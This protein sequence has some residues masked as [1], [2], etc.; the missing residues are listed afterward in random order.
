M[1]WLY[2]Y[3]AGTMTKCLLRRGVSLWEV[4]NVQCLYV[5][6]TMTKCLLRRDVCLWE[7]KNVVNV[8][9]VCGL[10]HD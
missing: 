10:N 7:I 3:V 1:Y 8:A 5:A 2:M 4:K 6:G 9:F